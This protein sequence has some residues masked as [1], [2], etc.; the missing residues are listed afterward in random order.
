[1]GIFAYFP[2]NSSE[3]FLSTLGERYLRFEKRM[4][5]KF[6]DTCRI[7]K[8]A[9]HSHVHIVWICSPVLDKHSMHLSIVILLPWIPALYLLGLEF[10]TFPRIVEH[11]IAI[12]YEDKLHVENS[13]A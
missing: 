8:I 10:R 13:D 3:N 11:V 5:T 1:M 9:R 4:K 7:S 2:G 12:S 6:F